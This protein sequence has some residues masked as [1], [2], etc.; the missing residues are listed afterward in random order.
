MSN[1]T[2]EKLTDSDFSADDTMIARNLLL[3]VNTI[4]DYAIIL[5]DP[6]GNVASWNEGA[7]RIKQYSASEIIGQ[8]FSVFYSAEDRKAQL[9]DQELDTVRANGKIETEGWRFRKDG[10]C[11]WANVTISR[12]TDDKGTIVGFGKM[13]RDITERIVNEAKI[14]DL[15]ELNTKML[16]NSPIGI[17]SF[18]ESGECVFANKAV[19][20]ISG[21]PLETMLKLNFHQ[22]P[23]WKDNGLH[24]RGCRV[25]ETGDEERCELHTIS[26]FGRDIWID[27]FMTS[28]VSNEAKHILMFVDDITI[29]KIL[30]NEI[31]Q[32]NLDLEANN[33]AL[34]K[35]INELDEFTYVASHDLQEP[36][37]KLISFS[38]LLRQDLPSTLPE[39]A[40]KDLNFIVEAS[41]R[42][43]TLIQ[44]LLELSRTGKNELKTALVSLNQCLDNALQ[45][46]EMLIRESGAK[47][48]RE[49]LPVVF[50]DE[51][52][53]SRVFQN[54]L[55]N[56]MKF[57][58]KGVAPIITIRGVM[59]DSHYQISIK[60]NGIGIDSKYREMIFAPFKRLHGRSEY[61]G[62]GIG[63]SI[64]RKIIERHGGRIWLDETTSDGASFSFTLSVPENKE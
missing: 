19:A 12:I 55:T 38:Q 58:Q 48:I 33:L 54:L 2:N 51:Q 56:A 27:Y 36:L 31:R 64:C 53:L 34:E 60:D 42:M 45:D 63:L 28:F 61:G 29:R 5:L 24:E 46:C 30:E 52:M 11:F 8:H 43:K 44:D 35:K 57:H 18:A 25:L 20:R 10:S 1:L 15:M 39:R 17:I 22:L 9:C 3:L 62:S 41:Y 13:T 37:R 49:D 59:S 47:I 16:N 40:E 7:Q 4:E 23:R 50:V 32:N 6:S 26:S 21:A 14:K